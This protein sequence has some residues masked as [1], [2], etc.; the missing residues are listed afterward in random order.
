MV[1]LRTLLKAARER[2]DSP[3]W[4]ILL[5]FSCVLVFSFAFH[6]KVAGYHHPGHVDNATSAK[7]WLTGDKPQT[8]ASLSDTAL[9]WFV[10][11]FSLVV[12]SSSF[13]GYQE[14]RRRPVPLPL[15]LR[16]LRRHLRPPPRS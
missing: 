16:N 3:I 6:A 9:L 15:N 11:W 13:S 2:L 4:R 14:H 10:A 1:S 7:L 12:A 5:V 8:R